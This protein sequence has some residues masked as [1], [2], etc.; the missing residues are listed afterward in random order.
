MLSTV[1]RH[2]RRISLSGLRSFESALCLFQTSLIKAALEFLSRGVETRE[3]AYHQCGGAGIRG[4][5]EKILESGFEGLIA[6]AEAEPTVG[7]DFSWFD[8]RATEERPTWRY[9]TMLAERISDTSSVLDIQTGDG[10]VFAE[11]LS[12]ALAP[13]FVAATE[14]WPPNAGRA[15]AT[16]K[17]FNCSVSEIADDSD[18]PFDDNSFE[19]VVSRH[20][21][22][23]LWK[24]ICRVLERGGTYFS[25]QVG[26]G[27]NRE[28]TDY[29]MG[30]QPVATRR[31]PETAVASAE[32]A[33]LDIVDLRRQTLE[34]KFFDVG[35]V[36]YFLRKVLWTVPG[37]SVL[38]YRDR[39]MD[40]DAEI[41]RDGAFI[42][43]SER[44]LIEATKR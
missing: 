6:E 38:R 36:V 35:A 8:G 27:S 32:A 16:L 10:L 9:V 43:H 44:F 26:A 37:F 5:C 7:W 23:V 29:F 30:P 17:P 33:G 22:V 40:M 19:L 13:E 34:V 12:N 24:E 18:L 2:P 21:T 15:N 39:L 25:Q 3:V 31:S 4:W 42:S 14:S 11:A 20:P 41:R 1:R 28:L